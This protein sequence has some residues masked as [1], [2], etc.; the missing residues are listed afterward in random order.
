M[1]DTFYRDLEIGRAAEE[2]VFNVFSSL[3]NK[4]EFQKVA[5]N[6]LFFYSGDILAIDKE[7]GKEIF[8]EVKNDSRI[9]DTHNVLCEEEVYYKRH[10]YYGRGNMDCDCDIYAVVSEQQRKIYVIDFKVLKSNYRKGEYKEIQHPHQTTYCYL[11][12][13]NKIKKL[14]GLIDVI[15]Y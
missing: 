15:N 3:D 4:H 5:D 1:I 13:I 8:I 6:P 2:I 10:D 7:T 11:L 12:N 9:A 14:G